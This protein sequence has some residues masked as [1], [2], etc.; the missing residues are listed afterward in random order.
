MCGQN[1]ENRAL[2]A[3]KIPARYARDPQN[4]P[5]AT[6]AVQKKPARYARGEGLP[7]TPHPPWL[8]LPVAGGGA[9]FSQFIYT[10]TG[11]P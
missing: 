5:R 1:R 9:K 11:G 4:T 3:Q 10:F 7:K 8:A 6:R 2:R